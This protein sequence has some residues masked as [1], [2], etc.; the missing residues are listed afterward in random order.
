M[1]NVAVDR[2]SVLYQ[3]TSGWMR[4]THFARRS[5]YALI[6]S[7]VVLGIFTYYLMT[8][9]TGGWAS[10][11]DI[12]L[13]L[14]IDFGI[15][16]LLSVLIAKR[17]VELWLERRKG[18]A[19]SKLH[20]RL[21]ILLSL[22]TIV[23][24]IVMAVFSAL[25]LN[26]GIHSWFSSRVQTALNQS[27]AVAE[28]YLQE[29]KKVIKGNAEAMAREISHNIEPL[30]SDKAKFNKFV[31]HPAEVRSLSDAIVF[32]TDDPPHIL[33]LSRFAYGLQLER[34]TRE[35]LKKA[36]GEAVILT[37]DSHYVVRALIRL[38][39]FRGVYLLV[40]RLVDP[41]V[42][43]R[44]ADT[45]NA[46]S[47]YRQLEK[48]LDEIRIT[49]LL[50]FIVIALL[51]LLVSIWFGLSYATQ[52]AHPISK[53]IEAAEKIRQG[54][55]SVRVEEGED[56]TELGVLISSFN[57]MT[58][59][60]QQ[61]QEQVLEANRQI[62]QRRQF[63]EAVL[64]GVT[65]GVI[66]LDQNRRIHVFNKS[67]C[68]LLDLNLKEMLGIPL[69]G[70]IPEMKELFERSG[71]EGFIQAQINF[72]LKGYT[73]TFL[74]RLLKEKSSTEMYGYV[75]TF[76][77]LTELM[78]AQRLSAWADVGRRIA[79][80]IKNPLT[81]IQLAAERLR[82]KYLNQISTDAESFNKC[83]DTISRQVQ[84]IGQMASEFSSFARMPSPTLKNT[85]IVELCRQNILFHHEAYPKCDLQFKSS[86]A[87][88]I[89]PCDASQIEQVLTNLLKNALEALE[90]RWGPDQGS[91]GYVHVTLTLDQE[92][93]LI[94]ISDNGEGL[95]K[96]G[97]ETLTDPY[98]TYKEKGTGLGLAIV[99]RIVEDH[100]G[101]IS[102]EDQE[103]GKVGAVVCL[104]FPKHLVKSEKR[105][106][107]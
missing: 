57:K 67:A 62:D 41:Q 30:I 47:D 8:Q 13:L 103:D 43:Q 73:R 93:L 28:A 36:K 31:D 19:G 77:D 107:P 61:Q 25:F 11:R 21:V 74:V 101:M 22:L 40:G 98:V 97:R 15:L 49:F 65:A 78:R 46:L 2:L 58:H 85:E 10:S 44:I 16:L 71:K 69:T 80:E 32:S 56:K 9:A 24:A 100:G 55:L 83:I 104:R 35:D 1:E 14:N 60:I 86:H 102:F 51:L 88:I 20:V 6:I 27:S 45:E 64:S 59:Q 52:L 94:I 39:P 48:R 12:F 3:R 50:I 37:D 29:H 63:I 17:L 90:A 26:A 81:P 87:S 53:L 54:D 89:F 96:S 72:D 84:H 18:L 66:G 75:I 105:K 95:P 76:D 99:R 33:A 4:R 92:E 23:P 34:V 79:H 82:R 91:E 7:A 38:E 70:V 5:A 42:L 106:A 68:E